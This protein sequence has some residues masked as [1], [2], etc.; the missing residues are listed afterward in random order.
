MTIGTSALDPDICLFLELFRIFGMKLII[1]RSLRHLPFSSSIDLLIDL[2][3]IVD[4]PVRCRG[5][6]FSSL[7]SSSGGRRG[8]RRLPFVYC[9]IRGVLLLPDT[10]GGG[11]GDAAIVTACKSVSAAILWRGISCDV[12]AASAVRRLLFAS[13]FPP[14][15][16]SSSPSGGESVLA[17]RC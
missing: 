11:G 10:A 16:S 1:G 17:R 14:I 5:A 4:D 12:S 2:V 8:R 9:R 13:A 15:P 7:S 6:S 3:L